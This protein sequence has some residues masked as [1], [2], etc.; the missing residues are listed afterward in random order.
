MPHKERGFF[1]RMVFSIF[2]PYLVF[3]KGFSSGKL[4]V[5]QAL[6]KVIY[7]KSMQWETREGP[8]EA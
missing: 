6:S 8:S 1:E 5:S 3:F 7:K 4:S 2:V